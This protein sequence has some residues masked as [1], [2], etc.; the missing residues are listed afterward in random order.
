MKILVIQHSAADPPAEA[1]VVLDRL[2]CDVRIVRIDRGEAIPET[3]DA[4]MLMMFGGAMSLTSPDPPPWL[5]QEKALIR[6]YVD[7]GQRVLG[8]CLGAQILASALGANVRRNAQP[9]VGWHKIEVVDAPKRSKLADLFPRELTVFQ[10][11]Q[12]TFEIPPGG[13][14]LMRS[15]ACRNQAFI[16]DDRILGCQFHMEA[17]AKT[18]RTFLAVSSL[19]KQSGTFVQSESEI[20]AG[21]E[22]YLSE[23][24][25]ALQNVL[26]RFLGLEVPPEP[27]SN[28]GKM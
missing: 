18:V 3:V 5:A 11:H 17:N 4:D 26:A 13:V 9:E 12:D 23:Q 24:N 16:V 2:G 25:L 21:I 19:W 27:E 1:A 8:I 10:W 15:T 22:R 7:E 14:R 28:L 20:T 6:R